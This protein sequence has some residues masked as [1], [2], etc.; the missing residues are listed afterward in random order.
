MQTF[1][2]E[3]E[4]KPSLPSDKITNLRLALI[5]EE[6]LELKEAMKNLQEK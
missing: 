5:E 3:V 6:L 2:Q 1:G 4:T